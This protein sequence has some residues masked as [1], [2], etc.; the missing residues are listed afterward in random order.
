MKN[1]FNTEYFSHH[2]N[3]K[4]DNAFANLSDTISETLFTME[5]LYTNTADLSKANHNIQHIDLVALNIDDTFTKHHLLILEAIQ[6]HL[7]KFF[8]NNKV[9]NL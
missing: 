4:I 3:K 5:L 7:N 2:I 9:T 8:E 1:K 6:G